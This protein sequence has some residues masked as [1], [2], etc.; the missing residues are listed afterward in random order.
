[1]VGAGASVSFAALVGSD[2]VLVMV[3]VLY[4]GGTDSD[5]MEELPFS[6]EAV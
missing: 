6:F 2:V 4:A 3:L 1:V 5:R